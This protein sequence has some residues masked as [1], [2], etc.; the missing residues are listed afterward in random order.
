MR[1]PAMKVAWTLV[2]GLTAT[3]GCLETTASDAQL[4]DAWRAAQSDAATSEDAGRGRTTACPT[5]DANRLAAGGGPSKVFAE[6]LLDNLDKLNSASLQ[7]C[8]A[9]KKVSVLCAKCLS[10]EASLTC[11]NAQCKTSCQSMA[12]QKTCSPCISQKCEGTL[13]VCLK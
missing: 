4:R 8:F 3:A 2:F 6:C 12:A 9:A 7:A 13:A 10:R 5:A 11:A 1:S